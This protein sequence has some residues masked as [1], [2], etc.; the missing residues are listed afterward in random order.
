MDAA[1]GVSADEISGSP[2]YMAPEQIDPGLARLC[3][4]TDVYALGSML[5]FMLTGTIQLVKNL[6][7]GFD[8]DGVQIRAA[9]LW[10]R[11]LAA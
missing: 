6:R 5:V 9:G 2:H 1:L 3:A 8:Q 4:A 11:K 7:H 10:L